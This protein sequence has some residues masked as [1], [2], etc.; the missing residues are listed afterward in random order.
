MNQQTPTTEFVH[1][2]EQ[3]SATQPQSSKGKTWDKILNVLLAVVLIVLLVTFVTKA[4]FVTNVVVSGDSMYPTYQNGQV[5]NVNRTANAQSVTRGDIVV[6]YQNYPGW[7]RD[8]F[9]IFRSGATDSNY[10]YRLLI[11]RVVAI[12]GDK[13][14]V[15]KV[16]DKYTVKIEKPDGQVV[17]ELYPAIGEGAETD[18]TLPESNF[19]ISAYALKRLESYTQSNPYTVPQGYFFAMGD[20]RDQ[21]HDS[22][23]Q[24]MGDIPYQNLYGKVMQ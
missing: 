12:E 5:V 19:Y 20:N 23:Y 10:Q 11:K 4:F 14:W 24:D 8:H 7:F 21:S 17:G 6:F 9:D 22:R 3:N 16:G 1:F 18:A 2:D 13:I 15:E